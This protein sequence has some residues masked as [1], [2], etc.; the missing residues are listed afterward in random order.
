M[1]QIS[2]PPTVKPSKVSPPDQPGQHPDEH[3]IP[4][5]LKM[6]GGIAIAIAVV[7]FVL[8]LAG[9]FL[10]GWIPSQKEA[11]LARNDA[12]A[13]ANLLPVVQYTMPVANSSNH[14]I[15]LPCNVK[16]NQS[17]AIYTRTNGYLSKWYFDIGQHVESGQ[18]MAT[19]DTPEVDAELKQSQAAL[20]QSK[21]A[22][23]KASADLK[24]AKDTLDRYREAQKSNPGSVTLED[25]E[26]RES[27]VEDAQAGLNQA[28]ANVHAADANVQ[29]LTVTAGFEK[30]YAPF[31]G[32]VTARNYDVGRLLSPTNTGPGSEIFDLAQTDLLRVFVNVPQEYSNDIK[33]KE[34]AKLYVRNFPSKAFEG[35]VYA[36][37]GA[38]DPNTRTLSVQI[39]F[40]NP[41]GELF[42]GEYG[43]IH[44]PVTDPETVGLIPTSALL[45]NA[46]A[47][48]L[49]VA[50]VVDGNK[51][52]IKPIKTGRD[53]GTTI[54]VTDGLTAADK[55][56]TN[57][58]E[59]VSEG[60]TVT[61][62]EAPKAAPTPQ[63]AKPTTAP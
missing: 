30:V 48:G 24:L 44:L 26:T 55:V 63:A 50:T 3:G 56:V 13:R 60:V 39:N 28:E 16:A 19:I 11:A 62:L 32:T 12:I 54:E 8:L 34:T 58:S 31:S 20:E 53:F 10:L 46:Q 17:T 38:V 6:P 43:E 5:D 47:K 18:L 41:D 15:T 14:D 45:F 61:A 51:I 4:S 29:Q 49:Q 9:L 59:R 33:L 23:D 27:A 37:A 22:V 25:V 35:I 57:P 2:T 21:A 52:H 42:A 7:V 40:P 36:T 1:T